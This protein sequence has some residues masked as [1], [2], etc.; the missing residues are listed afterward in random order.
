M[1]KL[2]LRN[3][4]RHKVRTAMTLFA[5]VA[6]VAS[7]IIS[8]GFVQDIFQQ[9]REFTIHS[10][11]GHIQIYKKGYWEF[12]SQAPL[13]YVI[14]DSAAL[15]Q[16]IR[17][18]PEVKDVLARLRFSGLI[19]NGRADHAIVGEGVEPAK[20]AALG[21]HVEMIAGRQL[22]AEDQFGIVVGEGVAQ[23]QQLQP[24]DPVTVLLN[25]K[26][27]A[28][29]SLDFEVIGVFRTFSKEFDARAVR[30]ALPAAQELLASPGANTLVVSL[31]RS[32]ST[33]QVMKALEPSLA[34]GYE[35]RSW[36]DLNDFY[37]KTVDL[38]DRQFGVLRLIILGMVLL[39]VAN[40][41]NMSVMERIGEFGTMQALG[42]RARDVFALVLTEN[43]V[44][45]VIGSLIGLFVGI[46][47]AL[48][49]SAIGIPMPP[50]P[51][52]NTGYIARIQIE[53]WIVFTSF[54][55]GLAAAC[56]AALLPARRVSRTAIAEALRYNI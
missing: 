7:L 48:A 13:D 24:G 52:S 50:P 33:R 56:G 14:E 5:V 54:F 39:G 42:N 19:N 26:E 55:V 45:G 47:V 1:F 51:N 21:T 28:L 20:E 41:V 37:T 40:S 49:I 18:L 15:E 10:Q 44:L 25:T 36:N 16:R 32:E 31:E 11:T 9:L 29:N 6:G 8:G 17:A 23:A 22:A 12:G 35:S 30:I 34:G 3:I 2:A 38:Y 53:P 4:T 46:A 43:L 27:G